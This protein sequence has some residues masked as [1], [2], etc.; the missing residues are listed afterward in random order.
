[1][2]LLDLFRRRPLPPAEWPARLEQARAHMDALRYRAATD[3]L[4]PLI[5][6]SP[7]PIAL[8]MLGECRFQSGD[9]AGALVPTEQALNSLRNGGST[10]ELLAVLGNLYEI[11]RYRG[12]REKAATAA[13]EMATILDRQG[14]PERAS[15]YRRQA[16]LV[17]AGEPLC[18]AV[19]ELNG[20]RCEV[21]EVIAGR[22]G[23]VRF[24]LERNRVTLR[25]AAMRV[26]EGMALAQNGRFAD[27][28]T[29]FLEAAAVD[30]FA[31]EPHYHAGL[32]LIYLERYSEAT[33]YLTACAARAPGWLLVEPALWFA[34]QLAAHTVAHETFVAWHALEEGPL[35][36]EMKSALV[37]RTLQQAP[38]LALL[39]LLHG[40]I[41]KARHSPAAEPAL[42]RAL[43]LAETPDVRTR[44][45]VELAGVVATIAERNNLLSRVVELNGDLLAVATARVVL[46]FA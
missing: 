42:R 24:V 45:M 10:E 4:R 2:G 40:K 1:V 8:L 22:A 11:H 20:A 6:S 19:A 37:E 29:L 23:T 36:A 33:T 39:H 21:D 30:A 9:S 25:P 7:L 38:R 28:L 43:D 41:L 18:R 35:T 15:Q 14:H 34:Q 26:E 44:A 46:A 27:A 17:R 3:L 13:E 5:A 12:D 31:P 16:A 32:S